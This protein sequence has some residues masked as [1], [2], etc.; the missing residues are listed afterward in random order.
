MNENKTGWNKIAEQEAKHRK[1]GKAFKTGG[2]MLFIVELTAGIIL[3]GAI[4]FAIIVKL[5]GG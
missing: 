1:T 2:K 3:V 5:Q 4:L